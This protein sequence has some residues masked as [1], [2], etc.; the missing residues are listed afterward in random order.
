MTDS[1]LVADLLR[2]ANRLEGRDEKVW[3][4]SKISNYTI[5]EDNTN[6]KK[7][8]LD[9][10]VPTEAEA[11]TY[12]MLLADFNIGLLNQGNAYQVLSYR[13]PKET[14]DYMFRLYL[15]TVYRGLNDKRQFKEDLIRKIVANKAKIYIA[16]STGKILY[17]TVT[18]DTDIVDKETTTY[19]LQNAIE[20]ICKQVEY[21]EMN[22]TAIIATVFTPTVFIRKGYDYS[23]I[24]KNGKKTLDHI[25]SGHIHEV[26]D[27]KE[28]MIANPSEPDIQ[29]QSFLI[30]D[31]YITAKQAKDMYSDHK[32]YKYIEQGYSNAISYNRET[33]VFEIERLADKT[34]SFHLVKETTFYYRF[35]NRKV[36]LVNNVMVYDDVLDRLDGMYPFEI[37]RYKTVPGNFYGVCLAQEFE[38]DERFASFLLNVTKRMAE[39]AIQPPVLVIGKEALNSNI[40]KPGAMIHSVSETKITPI[41][42]GADLNTALSL[43][44]LTTSMAQENISDQLGG[45]SNGPSKTATEAK[46]LEGNLNQM[47][48]EWLNTAKIF[49]KRYAKLIIGDVLQHDMT[50]TID[51]TTGE[52]LY[53]DIVNKGV[54]KGADTVDV[55]V[56]PIP[57]TKKLS[58]KK[59]IEKLK[60]EGKFEY[61]PELEYLLEQFDGETD[62]EDN[63]RKEVILFDA[64]DIK[65][66]EIS[67]DIDLNY[68]SN[69]DKIVKRAEFNELIQVLAP[70]GGLDPIGV[71]KHIAED[72][73]GSKSKDI[74]A[75]QA[76]QDPNQQSGQLDQSATTNQI[77]NQQLNQAL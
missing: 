64:D 26:I 42:T 27:A 40:Y 9:Y 41:N 62:K 4:E 30:R 68:L 15:A 51:E 72:Y 44:N 65:K 21:E 11:E 37:R 5:K 14:Q 74:I 1:K 17:P 7:S 47:S 69:Q 13:N 31:R 24:Y 55:V 50:P 61:R 70:L 63:K 6:P 29:R 59:Q 36:V 18:V 52:L 71:T 57:P 25:T 76:P 54:V 45:M 10:Y 73:L 19:A 77:L 48:N 3:Q 56:R 12:K 53:K 75:K 8:G 60:E 38:Q 33:N 20:S 35:E 66:L 23:Y 2:E 34:A 28:M 16:Q 46:L 43:L 58:L 39:F 49:T 22:R 67:V 32:N